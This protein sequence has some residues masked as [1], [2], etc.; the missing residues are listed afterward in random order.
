MKPARPSGICRICPCG[1]HQAPAHSCSLTQVSG[2]ESPQ[3]ARSASSQ[4]SGHSALR[5][6]APMPKLIIECSLAQIS[7]TA[8]ETHRC[9]RIHGL[10]IGGIAESRPTR[11]PQLWGTLALHPLPGCSRPPRSLSGRAG[12]YEKTNPAPDPFSTGLDVIVRVFFPTELHNTSC[13][14]NFLKV[15]HFISYKL[16]AFLAPL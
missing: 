11:L 1:R 5:F 9:F 8:E 14:L 7:G 3:D 15:L 16:G 4:S 12:R 2:A 6:G 13:L 10:S